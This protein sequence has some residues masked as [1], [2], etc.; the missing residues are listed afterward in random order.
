MADLVA[1]E[2]RILV[3]G[4]PPRPEL[5]C[6]A[7]VLD[8][9]ATHLEQRTYVPPAF[10]RDPAEPARPRA[11]QQSHEHGLCLILQ[12]VAGRDAGGADVLGRTDR[13]PVIRMI[14]RIQRRKVDKG[15]RH[16]HRPDAVE[17]ALVAAVQAAG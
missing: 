9:A 2:R 16:P 6:P 10:R 4:I 7:E 5:Q 3:G 13:E 1:Q 8:L 12:R 17:L 15:E 14:R 11:Q